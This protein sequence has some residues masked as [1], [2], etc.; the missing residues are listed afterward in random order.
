MRPGPSDGCQTA[1]YDFEVRDHTGATFYVEVKGIGGTCDGKITLSSNELR[2]MAARRGS[3]FFMIIDG[4]GTGPVINAAP[5]VRFF[6]SAALTMGD[7]LQYCGLLSGEGTEG[8]SLAT[9]VNVIAESPYPLG[10]GQAWCMSCGP[11]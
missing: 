8:E 10:A 9:H 2:V 1:G 4:L 3:Y 7:A 6:S 5:R 11:R